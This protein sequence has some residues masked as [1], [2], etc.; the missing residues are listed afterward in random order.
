MHMADSII[1]SNSMTQHAIAGSLMHVLVLVVLQ[2]SV[3][4]RPKPQ[5]IHTPL[6]LSAV[7]PCELRASRRAPAAASALIA[8]TLPLRA[9]TCEG[10]E[11]T[12][13]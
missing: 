10:A 5:T 7:L 2:E 4:G 8:F 3:Q 11:G 12:E 1:S 9:A 13:V 6:T